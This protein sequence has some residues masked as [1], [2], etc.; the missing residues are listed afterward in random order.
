M[1]DLYGNHIDGFPTRWLKY[2][3]ADMSEKK[4][5]L[6]GL[7]SVMNFFNTIVS[8]PEPSILNLHPINLQK[9]KIR[10]SSISG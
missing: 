7:V 4:V 2:F 10:T 3:I 1:S 6:P 9:I 5:T 8:I